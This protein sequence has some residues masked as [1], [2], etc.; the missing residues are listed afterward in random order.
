VVRRILAVLAAALVVVG[1]SATAASA[2]VRIRGHEE[3]RYPLVRFTLSTDDPTPLTSLNVRVTENGVP[4]DLTTLRA[5]TSSTRNVQVVLAID[6]SNSMSGAE[7]ETA[8]AAANDFVARVPSWISV[9]AVAFA[10]HPVVVSPIT[11]DRA[12]VTAAVSGMTATTSAGTALFGAID[13]AS[14][15][16]APGGQH[17]VIVLTDGR[18]TEAGSLDDAVATAK[19][20]H[21]T[22]FTIGIAGGLPDDEVLRA[23]ANR[24]GGSYRLQ[25]AEDLGA[26]YRSLALQLSQQYLIEYRS[27]T[28]YGAEAHIV[29]SVPGGSDDVRFRMPALP[30]PLP[31]T[32][33]SFLDRLLGGDVG[34]I[35][36]VLLVFIAA[37]MFMNLVTT[38]Y[39][40]TRRARELRER[41]LVAKSATDATSSDGPA[42]VIP[43]QLSEAVERGAE[44]AGAASGIARA[45]ERAGWSFSVGEFLVPVLFGPVIVGLVLGIAVHPFAGVAVV[46]LGWLLPV[47]MLFRAGRNRVLTLQGQLADVLM[48]LASSLRAGHSFLQ[49][50]DS[51]AKEIDEPA[52]SEFGR[53]LSEIQLGRS[54]DD[55]L[56]ALSARIG[57]LDLEWA[58][59]AINIQRKAGGNLAEVLETVAA[60]I[61]ERETLRRQ[62][63]AL[64]A[65]GR[66]SVVILIVL[67]F[68][69][70]GYM[71]IVSPG[72]LAPL[73]GGLF[74]QLLLVAGGVLM[75]IGYVWMRKIVRLDV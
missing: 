56:M 16:F 27:K 67:P 58:V 6:V 62:V 9:G 46:L 8:L 1:I 43:H 40:E 37:A 12:G 69:I 31:D 14:G 25:T 45:L 2:D 30:G 60:T 61:R 3:A 22:V 15:M 59:T 65:E 71:L 17:N 10:D 28:P 47:L 66:W 68:L 52:A 41:F 33:G 44:A 32:H 49:A 19:Q 35:V 38:M 24:T 73:I 63:R 7:L 48:I 74:G 29:V 23:L 36:V 26:A 34:A 57:S 20:A 55:A 11:D 53:A 50:L 4:V 13:A 70:L 21:A 39:E 42:H 64:S 5:L 18:N 51:V 72:Y 54:I 75:I